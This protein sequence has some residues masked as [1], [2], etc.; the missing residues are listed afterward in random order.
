MLKIK[1]RPVVSP[2]AKKLSGYTARSSMFFPKS[3][4][5][6]SLVSFSMVVAGQRR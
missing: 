4:V 6:F 1:S 5:S 3:L 2:A